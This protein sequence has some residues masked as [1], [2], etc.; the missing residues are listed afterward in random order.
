MDFLAH[1]RKRMFLLF[2]L[3]VGLPSLLL[4]YLAFRG[5]QN[6]QALLEKERLNEHRRIAE[7]IT[8]S[9]DENIFE[10]EQAFQ[11]TIA[12]RQ[13][14]SNIA[15]IHS[16]GDLKS[17]H[18]FVKEVFFFQNAGKIRFPMAKLLFLPDDST[19]SLYVQPRSSSLVRKI[20][21]GQ[22]LEFQQK[23]Y[24][25]ALTSY[26]QAIEQTSTRQIK[27]E[28]LS[29]VARV[30]K[31]S[32]LFQDAIK[33]YETIAQEFSQV[34]TAEGIPLGLAARLELGSLYL[35]IDDSSKAIE[36]LIEL[37]KALIQREWRLEKAQYDFFAQNINKSID[38]ILSPAS[39]PSSLESYGKT[40]QLLKREEKK[41]REITENL[42]IFQESA[43]MDLL[44]K[45]PQ[46][47]DESL[48][49]WKRLALELGRQSYLVS[50]LCQSIR[51]ENQADEFWG[52]LLDS[53]YLKD[54]LLQ[55]SI[56][57]HVSSEKT[58]WAVKGKEDET[59]LKSENFPS[60][61]MTVRA[62]FVENF[63]P[64]SLV[65]YQ[66]NPALFETF[67]TSRRGIY[68]YM[69]LLI[70]GILM[71][72][73][74]L[75]VRTV[76]REMELAKMK[77]D[78]VSAIS[79]EFKSPLTSIRQLAEMLQT[80]RIPSEERR[81]KYYD[82]LLEQSERLSLLTD[83]ILSFA[84]IEE[85]RKEF[86]FE[87]ADIGALLNDIVSTLQDRVC[88]EGFEIQ[89]DIDK[90]LPEIRIDT[91]AMTQAVTNLMDNAIKYSDKKKKIV[92]RSFTENQ[93]LII[94]VQDFGVGIKKEEIGKVFERFYR[95]GDELTRTVKGSGLG[96]TLVKQIV[97]AHQGSV[98]VE[99]EPGRGSTFS[100][101][102]PLQ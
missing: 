17:Q 10:V 34:R 53:D 69:F 96:L 9:I 8:Q 43:K 79:H 74:I 84:Q 18:H 63:P 86:K 94:A 12:N 42:L 58:E 52:L 27:G 31:K 99:S 19:Q 56:Q 25:E 75:T 60:G 3:G 2:F 47:Q 57:D 81:Q 82:V 85:G 92:T 80:G 64:W 46:E 48:R 32:K 101:I 76:A 33:S 39:L 59:I 4:G 77:S 20:R 26:E 90:S 89:I 61:S 73:L 67:L 62:N 14:G 100:I 15:L 22:Q 51:D 68:F 38:E 7:L 98:H 44:A 93:N 40:Y 30:Q 28:L 83:N 78:F 23:K 21:A 65:L 11:N 13:Q 70:A 29:A 54:I 87:M 66:Q 45:V 49:P 97:E 72:G 5:I 37:Y 91:A 71:F 1:K 88:H 36:T 41:Q 55:Q 35:A 102:L 50:L 16:L 24:R 6:D 95:G